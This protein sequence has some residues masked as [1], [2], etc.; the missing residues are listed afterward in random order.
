MFFFI[1][2][3]AGFNVFQFWIIQTIIIAY[4]FVKYGSWFEHF[5]NVEKGYL[6]IVI[7]KENTELAHLQFF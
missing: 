7:F 2:I 6:I 5:N 4:I 1:K 3:T